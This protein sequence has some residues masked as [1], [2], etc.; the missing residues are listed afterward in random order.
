MSLTTTGAIITS[1]ANANIN[2]T[3][4]TFTK[5]QNSVSVSA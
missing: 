5:Y 2:N 3:L 4:Y 1:Y